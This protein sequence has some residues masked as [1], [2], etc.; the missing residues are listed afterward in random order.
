M[1]NGPYDL[2]ITNTIQAE[3]QGRR[4]FQES[5]NKDPEALSYYLIDLLSRKLRDSFESLSGEGA[6]K[7]TTQVELINDL[8]RFLQNRDQ[9][10]QQV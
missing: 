6:E 3:L 7:T 9:V 2:L 5:L 1:K 4:A 8:L 10:P